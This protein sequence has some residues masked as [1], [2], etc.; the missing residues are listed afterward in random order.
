MERNGS[1]GGPSKENP[2]MLSTIKS[3]LLKYFPKDSTVISFSASVLES[4]P[5]EG[6]LDNTSIPERE[7]KR[8]DGKLFESSEILSKYIQRE[9]I[10]I[11]GSKNT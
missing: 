5:S 11:T 10:R 3:K 8:F 4:A 7:V 6:I 1:L 2:N 9:I